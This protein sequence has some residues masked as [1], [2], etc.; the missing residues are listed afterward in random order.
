MSEPVIQFPV[1]CPLCGAEA[2]A[3]YPVADVANALLSRSAELEL[4]AP[5]HDYHWTAS[6]WELQQV[7]QYMGA[8]LK[9]A[10]ADSP[11]SV[12]TG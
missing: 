9:S 10:P 1:T 7:R 2:M 4:Y 12:S 3:E 5:C 6:Q 8:W 11:S